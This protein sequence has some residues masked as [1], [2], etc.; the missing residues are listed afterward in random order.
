[1]FTNHRQTTQ[2]LID[3]L[4]PLLCLEDGCANS[5]RDFVQQKILEQPCL[6]LVEQHF[7][8]LNAL[9]QKFKQFDRF[10]FVFIQEEHQSLVVQVW[11][12]FKQDR[13]LAIECTRERVVCI[14]VDSF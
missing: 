5:L 2:H 8:H 3:L 1:M 4:H 10:A 11:P 6:F 14:A 7:L 12:V 13:L 9:T